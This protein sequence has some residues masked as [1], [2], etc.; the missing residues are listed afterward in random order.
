MTHSSSRY[1]PDGVTDLDRLRREALVGG[2]RSC[3]KLRSILG[4]RPDK[5]AMVFLRLP[6]ERPTVENTPPKD[7]GRKKGSR[8]AVSSTRPFRHF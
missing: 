6:D 4:P 5:F 8:S 2:S 1:I 7:I 3:T